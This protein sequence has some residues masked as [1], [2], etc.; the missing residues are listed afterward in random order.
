MTCIRTTASRA[1]SPSPAVPGAHARTDLCRRSRR[2]MLH[3]RQVGQWTAGGG[4]SSARCGHSTGRPRTCNHAAIRLMACIDDSSP[5][6]ASSQQ[7]YDVA[8]HRGKVS[9]PTRPTPMSFHLAP[10]YNCC[11]G[12]RPLYRRLDQPIS[13]PP[14]NTRTF[15]PWHRLH[16]IAWPDAAGPSPLNLPYACTPG[17]GAGLRPA[18]RGNIHAPAAQNPRH[19]RCPQAIGRTRDAGWFACA[20]GTRQGHHTDGP[21]RTSAA[22]ARSRAGPP[23]ARSATNRAIAAAT[24]PDVRH[25]TGSHDRTHVQRRKNSGSHEGIRRTTPPHAASRTRGQGQDEAQLIARSRRSTC[26]S[27]RAT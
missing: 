12:W 18:S 4:R 6:A 5:R 9:G 2:T 16:G 10:S 21:G 26:R 7:V 3:V 14:E 19:E 11:T 25:P 17:E 20:R 15:I 1:Q 22:C 13:D 27:T 8:T 23:R 24:D